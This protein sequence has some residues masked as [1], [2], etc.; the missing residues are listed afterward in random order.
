MYSLAC[1]W[2]IYNISGLVIG[3]AGMWLI[4]AIIRIPG[5]FC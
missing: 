1:T 4:R 5:Q 3:V 2:T